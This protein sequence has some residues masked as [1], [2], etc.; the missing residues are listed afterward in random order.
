M[1]QRDVPITREQV[2]RWIDSWDGQG[3]L[4]DHVRSEVDAL[5]LP[6]P[7]VNTFAH[8]SLPD[9]MPLADFILLDLPSYAH[10]AN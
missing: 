8:D 6:D 1:N 9:T 5:D 4:E 3:T 2:Q 7:T 10:S